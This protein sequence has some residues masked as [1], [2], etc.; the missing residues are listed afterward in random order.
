MV[1]PHG[2][3][4]AR[5]APARLKT[6]ITFDMIVLRIAPLAF[7]CSVMVLGGCSSCQKA[8]QPSLPGTPAPAPVAA[9]AAAPVQ[10][11]AAPA[12]DKYT[13]GSCPL[14][15]ELTAVGSVTQLAERR[16]SVKFALP[17]SAWPGAVGPAGDATLTLNSNWTLDLRAET[18]NSRHVYA[19]SPGVQADGEGD[20]VHAS[21]EL[22][23]EC[24]YTIFLSGTE[25]SEMDEYAR[26]CRD[27]DSMQP[28]GTQHLLIRVAAVSKSYWRGQVGWGA[29]P[30]ERTP[31]RTF[32]APKPGSNEAATV[33][34][35]APLTLQIIPGA[36]NRAIHEA[37]SKELQ[38]ELVGEAC[39]LLF[40]G[41]PARK[42]RELTE[43]Y[44]VGEAHQQHAEA[45]A[46]R[47]EPVTGPVAVK[48][49][50]GDWPYDVVVVTGE[51]LALPVR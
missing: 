50:P 32:S 44:T 2:S 12:T 33:I 35:E 38:R 42:P 20:T 29:T 51:R 46:R 1:E 28:L 9:S 8:T 21:C 40:E 15:P 31:V 37:V 49:W 39:L 26:G 19:C 47:L 7:V 36:K 34:D 43:V 16:G 14:L 13:G 3:T 17:P 22:G 24:E 25:Q 48:T 5:R 4:D 18:S 10:S 6:E 11:A 30:P 41:Q 27:D 45:I 23:K